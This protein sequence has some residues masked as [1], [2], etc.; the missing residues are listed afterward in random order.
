LRSRPEQQFDLLMF[1]AEK[2]I[3]TIGQDKIKSLINPHG[4][5]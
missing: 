4:N 3:E 2:E 1:K 5:W